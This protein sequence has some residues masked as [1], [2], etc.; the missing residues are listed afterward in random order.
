MEELSF[1]LD[2]IDYE[3]DTLNDSNQDILNNLE[4]NNFINLVNTYQLHKI[5][6]KKSL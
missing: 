2:N 5:S 1:K 4:F 3:L 6:K